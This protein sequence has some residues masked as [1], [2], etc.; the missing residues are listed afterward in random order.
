MNAGQVF[1]ALA[2]MD[3]E[4]KIEAKRLDKRVV[5]RLGDSF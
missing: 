4:K 2:R 3:L 1:A 5:T